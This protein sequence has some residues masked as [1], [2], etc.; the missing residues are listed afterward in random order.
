MYDNPYKCQVCGTVYPYE[1]R[2][3][4]GTRECGGCW[5]WRKLDGPAARYWAEKIDSLFE[6]GPDM[7]DV[8]LFHRLNIYN[9]VADALLTLQAF[10]DRMAIA[11]EVPEWRHDAMYGTIPASANPEEMQEASE[12]TL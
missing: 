6:Q 3:H 1:V 12:A 2:H 5:S 11:V 10:R 4:S 9:E 8:E 7:Y